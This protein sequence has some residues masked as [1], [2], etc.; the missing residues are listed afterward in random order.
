MQSGQ[1]HQPSRQLPGAAAELHPDQYRILHI[2][3]L[4]ASSVR[5]SASASPIRST[6][7]RCR[8]TAPRP[9]S[10]SRAWHSADCLVRIRSPEF[11]PA[12]SFRTSRINRIDNPQRPHSGQSLFVATEIA[13][14]GGNTQYFKPIVEWKKFRPMN[15]GRNTLGFRVQGSWISGYAGDVAPPFDRFYMGGDQDLRGFDIRSISPVVFFPTAI[16]IPLQNPDGTT[17]PLDPTNPRRGTWNVTIPVNQI[18]F[19]GGDTSMVANVEYRVPIIGPVTLAPFV[20][21][22][23]DFITN[24]SQLRI[25]SQQIVTLQCHQLRVSVPEPELFLRGHGPS[26]DYGQSKPDFRNQLPAA[27]VHRPGV[28]GH[29]ADRECA[30]PHLLRLQPAAAGRDVFRRSRRSPGR[31]SRRVRR[32][33]TPTPMPPR[34]TTRDT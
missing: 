31:C 28:A 2:A 18:I 33:T 25:A 9:L 17:V 10:T 7:R 8:P 12:R 3:Q 22:G 21:T 23:M 6:T 32:A 11:K 1:N 4:S 30:V 19:P 29:P 26:S 24:N 27:Y 15:K 14:L 13:G 16:T 20:D 34:C 5:S